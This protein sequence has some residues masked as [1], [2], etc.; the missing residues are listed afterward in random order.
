MSPVSN[1]RIAIAWLPA[2]LWAAVLFLLSA[3]PGQGIPTVH[4]PGFDKVVHA[5]VYAVAG[6]LIFRA[7]RRTTSLGHA[8]AVIFAAVIA[9]A[10]GVTDEIHQSFVPF[11]EPDVRDGL[12]DAAG[13]LLGAFIGRR[14]FDSRGFDRSTSASASKEGRAPA[15]A[16]S[17]SSSPSPSATDAE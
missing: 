14:L 17:S 10:Y 12:A 2:V 11:R 1:L 4:V 5:A 13:G 7:L 8:R 16:P 3:I 9:T 6:A 15:S